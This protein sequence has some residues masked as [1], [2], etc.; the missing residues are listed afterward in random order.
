[1]ID[2]AAADSCNT[3]DSILIWLSSD[4]LGIHHTSPSFLGTSDVRIVV[5]RSSE[6]A[7]QNT[8]HR[9]TPGLLWNI[10]KQGSSDTATQYTCNHRETR[11]TTH[12]RET[13]T[14]I[15]NVRHTEKLG[16]ISTIQGH[17]S[18]GKY[19]EQ[20]AATASS[21][22]QYHHRMALNTITRLL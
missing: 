20:K 15:P 1:M 4:L 12:Y 6:T 3:V 19:S 11:G 7:T 18:I 10:P 14:P 2:A 9:K 13:Q 21:H 8:N 22:Q 17:H 5:Q 16:D